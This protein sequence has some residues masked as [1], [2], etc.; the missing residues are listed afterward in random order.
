MVALGLLERVGD[1][2]RNDPVAATFL[3]GGG[4]AD[5]RPFLRFWD[6]ISYPAWTDLAQALATGP[7]QEVFELDD[8]LQEVVSAG[9]EAVLAGPAAALPKV[10]DFTGHRRLLDVGGGT[11]S[12]T[13][14]VARSHPHLE[15][16]VL[17]LPVPAE[18]AR[19]R[20][21]AAGLAGRVTAVAGDAMAGE[22][23]PG[24]DVFLVANLV[25]YWSPGTNLALLQRV[26]RA[27][28]PGARAP[29][30][31]L[32]RPPPHPAPPGPPQGR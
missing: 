20:M 30:R 10:V 15:A 2:Y 19:Q 28:E 23:P 7:T 26:R 27:A 12:W 32:D 29:G 14:A 6:R 11:G 16:T 18:M 31:L 9:I 22:L 5:L 8:E 21:E 25:H 1:L 24:H 17:D 4:P 13:V 3:A